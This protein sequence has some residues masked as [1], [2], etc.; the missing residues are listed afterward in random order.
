[1]AQV[2]IKSNSEAYKGKA[3]A[4][5]KDGAILHLDGLNPGLIPG[6]QTLVVAEESSYKG[7]IIFKEVHGESCRLHVRFLN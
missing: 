3:L 7:K 1:M 5:T 6:E 4:L 2:V